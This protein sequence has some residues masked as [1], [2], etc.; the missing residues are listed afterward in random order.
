MQWILNINV[1][2]NKILVKN[3]EIEIFFNFDRLRIDRI[4]IESD[5][6]Q[7]LKI[8]GFSIGRKTHLIDRNFVNLN[9]WKTAKD[10]AENNS[11]QVISWMKCMKMSLN[12]FQK[13]EFSTQNFKIK[14]FTL[15]IPKISN[16]KHILHQNQG[17]YNLGWSKQIHTQYHILSLVK[18]NMCSVCN[19]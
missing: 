4:P 11:T 9:F 13:H 2:W 10:Y 8:K 19:S 5:R 15:F 1:A 3:L 18:N 14:I 6:E 16:I 7:W 12:V 17:T